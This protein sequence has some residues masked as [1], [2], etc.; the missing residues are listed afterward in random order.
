M[1]RHVERQRG[2]ILVMTVLFL[3]ILLGFAALALDLGRLYVLRTEM[4]NAADASALAAAAELDGDANARSDAV[5]AAKQLLSHR[6]RFA[7]E[8]E[9]LSILKDDPS[10]N[11]EDNA[12]EFYSWINAE[13]DDSTMPSPCVH[14]LT[15][16][17]APD[18][19]KCLA[20]GDEDAHYIKVKLYPELVI[21]EKEYFQISLY[22]LPVLGLFVE[23]GTPFTASTRVSAVAGAGGPIYC[24][25]PPLFMC[26]YDETDAGYPGIGIGEEVKL[27]DRA[28]NTPW[29][30]G[31]VGFLQVDETI[32]ITADDG[33]TKEYKNIDAL[34]AAL[35]NEFI[36]KTCDP[37]IVSTQ[38][39]VVTQKT[40]QAFNT[41]F[42][43]YDG[44]FADSKIAFPPAPISVDYPLDDKFSPESPDYDVNAFKGDGWNDTECL[45]GGTLLAGC[46]NRTRPETFSRADYV[47]H[48]HA[49]P[50]DPALANDS[51]YALYEWE[52]SSVLNTPHLSIGV[53]EEP[54]DAR[55]SSSQEDCSQRSSGNPGSKY[56]WVHDGEPTDGDPLLGTPER[57]IL[58]VAVIKCG[59]YNV[60]GNTPDINLNQQG[61]FPFH[62]FF[63]TQ[64]AQAASSAEFFAE[65]VGP[66]SDE[67]E[68]QEI[69]HTV[70]QLYE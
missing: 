10:A 52:N 48:T 1:K 23:D 35:G 11:P 57:R 15:D 36:R 29:G 20:T 62:K 27:K 41:R 69:K 70:I 68:I 47:S 19:N 14:P 13:L 37:A 21:D 17:G 55:N 18:N 65:Y 59:K 45:V 3:V 39:G 67:E 33:S 34:A 50:P 53:A 31:N 64:H 28:A 63:L 6:G 54:L 44:Q 4:Q 7:T 51:R 38:T 66:V 9:L 30:P 22:F 24:K 16:T 8:T 56:C 25:Y 58:R 42:G 32:T 49:M 12:F 43:L 46:D 26:A 60:Q 40:R 61:D 2:A 5:L